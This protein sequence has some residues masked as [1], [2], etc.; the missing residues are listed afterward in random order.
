MVSLKKNQLF[1]RC[2]NGIDL[3]Y[4]GQM[5]FQEPSSNIMEYI[6]D[7][8][9]E[10]CFYLIIV[11]VFI[12]WWL[13]MIVYQFSST[14]YIWKPRFVLFPKFY[15]YRGWLFYSNEHLKPFL[16]DYTLVAWTKHKNISN[17]WEFWWTVIPTIFLVLISIPSLFLIYNLDKYFNIALNLSYLIR[18]TGN[19]WYWVYEYTDL[20]G[21]DVEIDSYMILTEDLIDIGHGYR[22]LDVDNRIYLME[23]QYWQFLISSNDVIHSWAVPSLGLKIDACPGRLNRIFVRV[24]RCGVFFGQCSEICGVLHGFMPITVEVL[25]SFKFLKIS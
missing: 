17:N 1:D 5:C 15:N 3:P 22:L 14:L 24:W 7:V 4:S 6:I 19:Q 13:G 8:H 25:P 12:S 11:M 23:G 21:K 2:N 9:H 18:I 16:G 20:K 10:I